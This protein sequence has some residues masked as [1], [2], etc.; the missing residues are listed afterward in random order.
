MVDVVGGREQS[1]RGHR[2]ARRGEAMSVRRQTIAG[3]RLVVG[4][5]G[6]VVCGCPGRCEDEHAVGRA[7]GLL[8][9]GGGRAY[10]RP[11]PRGVNSR[12]DTAHARR[13]CFFRACA[14]WPGGIRARAT[15]R[16]GE[17]TCPTSRL[18]ARCAQ[19]VCIMANVRWG[20]RL[21]SEAGRVCRRTCRLCRARTEVGFRGDLF[22]ARPSILPKQ[23]EKKTNKK[24]R[25]RITLHTPSIQS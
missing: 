10:Q 23:L 14:T 2:R 8:S 3:S 15:P 5:V 16:A 24:G 17:T 9:C 20:C 22:P 18:G 21:P 12:R 4:V 13:C 7:V 6:V 25:I 1:S 11:W 19:P